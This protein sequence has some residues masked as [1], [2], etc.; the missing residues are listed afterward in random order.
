MGQHLDGVST[1]GRDENGRLAVRMRE[2]RGDD[3]A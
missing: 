1:A 3:G 2:M